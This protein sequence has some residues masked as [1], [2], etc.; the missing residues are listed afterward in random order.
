[1]GVPRH[2]TLSKLQQTQKSSSIHHL[3]AHVCLSAHALCIPRSCVASPGVVCTPGLVAG[4]EPQGA[5]KLT[6]RE[7]VPTV[8]TCLGKW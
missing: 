2:Y 3:Q 1:M 6:V 8:R 7:R 5:D 4:W